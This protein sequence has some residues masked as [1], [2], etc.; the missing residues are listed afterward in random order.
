MYFF[1]QG[2]QNDLKLELCPKYTDA[3]ASR[4]E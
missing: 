1:G 2:I 4:F 3:P